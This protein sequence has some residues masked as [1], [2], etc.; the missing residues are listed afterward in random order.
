[1]GNV[2]NWRV[3]THTEQDAAEVRM[4]ANNLAAK[5]YIRLVK[6]TGVE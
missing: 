6:L 2:Y 3:S 5:Q 1:M 4:I